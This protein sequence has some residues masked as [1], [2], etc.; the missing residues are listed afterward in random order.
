M[1]GSRVGAPRVGGV[2]VYSPNVSPGGATSANPNMPLSTAGGGA[3][4]ARAWVP[5]RSWGAGARQPGRVGGSADPRRP[6]PDSETGECVLRGRLRSR[7]GGGRA[8]AVAPGP[9]CSN[10]DQLPLAPGPE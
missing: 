4:T 9:L 3:G 7:S 1:L 10:N 8:A 2:T 5:D 6:A